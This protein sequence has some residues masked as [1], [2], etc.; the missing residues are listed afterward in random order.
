MTTKEKIQAELNNLDESQLSDLY[1]VIK[2]FTQS[3]SIAN[4]KIPRCAGIG[5]S[6]MGN[7]SERDEELLWKND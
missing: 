3:Q 2:K 4:K 1:L 7:L 5:E 6:G